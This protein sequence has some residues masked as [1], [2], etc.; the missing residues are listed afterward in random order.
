MVE[1][2][3]AMIIFV[4]SLVCVEASYLALSFRSPSFSL[5]AMD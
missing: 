5:G 4:D 3:I 2:R 1:V